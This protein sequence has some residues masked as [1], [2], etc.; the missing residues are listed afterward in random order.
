MTKSAPRKVAARKARIASKRTAKVRDKNRQSPKNKKVAA[1]LRNN[2]AAETLRES[3]RKIEVR[4]QVP[5]T[6]RDLAER[7]VAQAREL[8][9]GSKNT[10]QV[11]LESW[12]KTFGAA[13]EG[14]ATLNRRFIDVAESNINTSFDLATGLA[15]ARN[16]AEVM[17]LQATYWRK[18]FS[19][20][21][22]HQRGRTPS[23]K[24][25]VPSRNR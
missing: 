21:Q 5:D 15:G 1:K 7:N 24:A 19:E 3:H 4:S 17:E 8:F 13:G 23:S 25:R 10:F 14:A 18:L 16:L 22:A 20:L 11:V 6:F 12:Q 2:V 9:E